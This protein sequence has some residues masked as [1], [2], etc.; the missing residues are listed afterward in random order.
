MV[1]STYSDVLNFPVKDNYPPVTKPIG[2]CYYNNELHRNNELL[3][4]YFFFF[5]YCTDLEGPKPQKGHST[6]ERLLKK[7]KKN[8]M[9]FVFPNHLFQIKSNLPQCKWPGDDTPHFVRH[10]Q[11]PLVYM[12]C[13]H[14]LPNQG[15]KGH[16]ACNP[17]GRFKEIELMLKFKLKLIFLCYS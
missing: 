7:K 17:V 3:S 5:R 11:S 13:H 1:E 16:N 15:D 12:K 6:H 2:S 8:I 10:T 4:F 14:P 9:S